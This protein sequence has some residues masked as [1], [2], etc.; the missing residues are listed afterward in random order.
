MLI[1]EKCNDAC[2]APT[3]CHSLNQ[4]LR[5]K[6]KGALVEEEVLSDGFTFGLQYPEVQF[7]GT[8]S[9]NM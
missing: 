7:Y 1:P 2:L 5:L 6:F 3:F 9:C 4:S 8:D